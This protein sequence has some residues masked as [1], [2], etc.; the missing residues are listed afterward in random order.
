MSLPEVFFANKE[1]NKLDNERKIFYISVFEPQDE[2][3]KNENELAPYFENFL[4]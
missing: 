4:N 1:K 2:F 3:D